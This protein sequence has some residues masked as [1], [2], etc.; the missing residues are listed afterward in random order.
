VVD[1]YAGIDQDHVLGPAE[2]CVAP[3]ERLVER[4]AAV[5]RG[6]EGDGEAERSVGSSE[7]H[8]GASIAM[9]VRGADESDGEPA[10]H[11]EKLTTDVARAGW[12]V[13]P[14][15]IERGSIE[16]E[17]HGNVE[18]E[19][20]LRAPEL[21]GWAAYACHVASTGARGHDDEDERSDP[22]PNGAMERRE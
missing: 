4:G 11:F 19:R 10:I 2:F 20:E 14:L 22:P 1:W 5:A 6:F 18:V 13:T 21:G 9:P 8:D 7:G 15:W 3:H 12:K 17:P 16:T